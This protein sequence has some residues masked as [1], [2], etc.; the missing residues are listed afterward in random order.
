MAGRGSNHLEQ[1]VDFAFENLRSRLLA[2][3]G[4]ALFDAGTACSHVLAC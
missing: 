2:L 3:E 1:L 4:E